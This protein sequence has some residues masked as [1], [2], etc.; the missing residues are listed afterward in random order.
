MS[1]YP[2]RRTRILTFS[3]LLLCCMA[4]G[5]G[6]E[7]DWA[8]SAG[9]PGEDEARGIVADAA[10]RSYVTGRFEGTVSFGN[11][12][13]TSVGG[14]DVFVEKLNQSG[15]VHWARSFGG[16]LD[17]DVG[18][19]IALDGSGN[20]YTTGE[21][22]DVVDFDPGNRTFEHTSEGGSDIF[23]QK[24]H[25]NGNF[26]WVAAMGGTGEDSGG[27]IYVDAFDNVYTVG[28]FSSTVDFDP[29]TG[30]FDLSSVADKDIF[31]QKL[32]ANGNLIWAKSMGGP[33]I[34]AGLGIAVD[35]SG[36]VYTT[37]FF[38]STVDFDPGPDPFDLTSDGGT[39]IF[40]QKLD[41][42]G[43]FVWAGAMSGNGDEV[44][45]SIGVD[46]SGNVYVAGEFDQIV[47]FDPGPG[48]LNIMSSGATVD[49]FIVKLD[50]QGAL[51]WAETTGG[52][53]GDTGQEIAVDWL[54]D[55][56]ATGN[57]TG[58]VDFDPGP[59]T[60]A[61]ESAGGSSDIFI[62][63]LDAN[64]NHLWAESAG[65]ASNDD[66]GH[67]IAIDGLG[68]VYAAGRF[69]G[70]GDFDPGP[71]TFALESAGLIDMFALKLSEGPVECYFKTILGREW[72]LIA[73]DLGL[74]DDEAETPDREIPE[75]WGISMVRTVLCNL[76]HP[77]HER[78][79]VVHTANVVALQDEPA[80]VFDRVE[81]FQNVLAAL[82]LIN[83]SRQDYFKALLG[84]TNTYETV[85]GPKRALSDE[86]FSEEGDLDGDGTNN[87]VEY[88]NVLRS[89]GTMED[90][91]EAT[92]DPGSRGIVAA[93]VMGWFGLVLLGSAL[94]L[95]F[96]IYARGAA[97]RSSS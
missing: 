95:L 48:D 8:K 37:G 47:D 9:G 51:L 58:T 12:T 7:L 87:V 32:D 13:L 93:P 89:G 45:Q 71:M 56:Y 27:D 2:Y 63:K 39:D 15:G 66:L 97:S 11:S 53:S 82:L 16:Q 79:L 57:Y 40:V 83:Q 35:I 76:K 77:H 90:F 4:R 1:S 91:A 59:L 88:D 26:A 44:G 29:G 68:N 54:G 46:G 74:V 70:I 6:P 62:R 14:G 38:S 86:V 73:A 22:L 72:L 36:N 94:L 43:N 31:I 50:W 80:S 5:Q 18:N 60:F 23:V 67:A 25:A 17:G 3:C 78:T 10:G 49:A 75:R 21:F 85:R 24:L 33:G 96:R 61:L 42:S 28:S 65:G 19:G 69:A 52:T 34:D 30:V 64:G 20:V 41:S 84:L 55:V 81:P 92:S